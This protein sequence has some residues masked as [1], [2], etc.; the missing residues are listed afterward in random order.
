MGIGSLIDGLCKSGRISYAWK[1]VDEMCDNGQPANIFTY[2]SLI[3]A[4]CKNRHVDKAIALVKKIKDQGI[5]PDMYTYNILIDGLCKGGRLKNAQDV[6]QD[7]L[8]KGYS[9]NIRT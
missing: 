1:L 2:N 6:F 9:L 4:L 5:Q 3:D 7:L 8:I